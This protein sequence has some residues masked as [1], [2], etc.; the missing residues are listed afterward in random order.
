MARL[1]AQPIQEAAMTTIHIDNTVHDYDAWKETFDKFDRF[2]ADNGVRSYS[3]SRSVADPQR[4]LIDLEFD[5]RA[6]A[7]AFGQKLHQIHGT[8]QAHSHLITTTGPQVME[9][10]DS[11]TF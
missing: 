6:E 5:T 10:V 8:P 11:K 3:M 7:E 2:R 9:T 4:V 1:E